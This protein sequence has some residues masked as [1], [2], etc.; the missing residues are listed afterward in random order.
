MATMLTKAQ[1]PYTGPYSIDG[2]GKHRGPT[3]E[4][5][6][7]TMKRAG[8]GFADVTLD[9]LDDIYNQRLEDALD[10]AFKDS[11]NGYGEG[12]W[13]KVRSLKL[14]TGDFAMDAFSQKMIQAELN[15]VQPKVPALGPVYRG[16]LSILQQDLT[17]ATD[18]IQ[19]YPAFD[20]AFDEGMSLIA[21]EHMVVTRES[22]SRPGDACYCTGDSGIRYWFGHQAYAPAVGRRFNKGDVFG[23]VAANHIGGGPHCHVGINVE[24]IW[25]AG[26]QLQHHTNYTHGAPLVGYQLSAHSIL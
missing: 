25:G 16:G 18:G 14:K 24:G 3:A 10:K 8:F 4:A 13:V 23:R 6:K 2:E 15:S 12:R 21:P 11:A 19:Y 1:V 22:S 20:T 9:E 17:H 26:K 5:L 7:R